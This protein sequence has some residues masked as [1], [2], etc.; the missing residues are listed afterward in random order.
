VHHQVDDADEAEDATVVTIPILKHQPEEDEY[1]LWVVRG[2]VD[3]AGGYGPLKVPRVLPPPGPKRPD[4]SPPA[5]VP[6]Q[7]YLPAEISR[8]THHFIHHHTFYY[9]K[10]KINGLFVRPVIKYS[11]IADLEAEILLN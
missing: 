5:T 11:Q 9:Y 4:S 1:L 3:S 2:R 7:K 8:P 6:T 10:I